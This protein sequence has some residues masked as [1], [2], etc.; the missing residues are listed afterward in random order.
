MR[1]CSDQELLHSCNA[2]T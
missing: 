1:G 2:R